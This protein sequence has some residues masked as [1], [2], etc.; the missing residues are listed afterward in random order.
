MSI[1][2]DVRS[3]TDSAL[4]QAQ[5]RLTEVR[6]DATELASRLLSLALMT[7]AELRARAEALTKRA[8]A[9]PGVEQASATV[10]PYVA[11][12]KGYSTI[13]AERLEQAYAELRK[14]DQ[15]AKVIAVAETSIGAMQERV[16]SLLERQPTAAAPAAAPAEPAAKA[17]ASAKTSGAAKANA[18]AKDGAAAK[19]T[20][21][22]ETS[23]AKVTPVKRTTTRRAT[24]D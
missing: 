23:T 17:T 2:S 21:S 4:E 5:A 6:G 20:P 22:A 7:C 14:N 1:T 16:T 10:E 11:Q 9:L 13:A 8:S 12:L 24:E 18:T 15:A 19:A 3:Y